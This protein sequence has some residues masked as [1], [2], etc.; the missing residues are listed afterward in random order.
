MGPGWPQGSS[1]GA[2][3]AVGNPTGR[4]SVARL[5]GV[6]QGEEYTQYTTPDC[7]GPNTAS[8]P[9][10]DPDDQS[11][12]PLFPFVQVIGT[13]GYY[14]DPSTPVAA[15]P[16]RSLKE[17]TYQ[18]NPGTPGLACKNPSINTACSSLT[19]AGTDVAGT[20]TCGCTLAAQYVGTG[21]IPFTTIDLSAFKP[22]FRV[23]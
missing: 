22:P 12:P 7:T 23:Q 3:A 10:T 4:W 17:E 15:Q 5:F 8:G 11:A 2:G 1:R 14:V 16:I 9:S 21:S 20:E 6:S 18:L 19:V 13:T